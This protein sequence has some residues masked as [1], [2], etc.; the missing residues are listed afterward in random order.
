MH[1]TTRQAALWLDHEEARIYLIDA[2]TFAETGLSVTHHLL[3]ARKTGAHA[4]DHR[5]DAEDHP[6]FDDVAA[7]LGEADEILVVG[8][9]NAKLRFVDYVKEHHKPLAAKIVGVEA[10]DHPTDKQLVAHVRD[11]FVALHATGAAPP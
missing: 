7:H 9:A 1:S 11:Y 4:K 5:R 6:F 2:E 10:A 8:P 3:G